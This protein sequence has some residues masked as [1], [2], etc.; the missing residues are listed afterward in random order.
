MQVSQGTNISSLDPDTVTHNLSNCYL[1]IFPDILESCIIAL[2]NKSDWEFVMAMHG[3][4]NLPLAVQ[5][6]QVLLSIVICTKVCLR[7]LSS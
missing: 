4:Q 6:S 2:V 1:D 5:V 7:L 3:G